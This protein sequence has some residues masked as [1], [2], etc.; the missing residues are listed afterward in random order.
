[1]SDTL[2]DITAKLVEKL[3]GSLDRNAPAPGL[4]EALCAYV[5][6]WRRMGASSTSIVEFTQRLVDRARGPGGANDAADARESDTVVAEVL[7]RCFTLANEP[8][9]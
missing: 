4:D 7:A 9:R 5:A 6:Y 1:M 3:H 2:A 8:R